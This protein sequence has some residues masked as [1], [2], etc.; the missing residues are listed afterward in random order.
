M[1]VQNFNI[2]KTLSINLQSESKGVKKTKFYFFFIT[3]SN[4][5]IIAITKKTDRAS[6]TSSVISHGF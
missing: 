3:M 2:K 5:A 4:N 6:E 1:K